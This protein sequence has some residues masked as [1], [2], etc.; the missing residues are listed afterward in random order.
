L[1]SQRLEKTMASEQTVSTEFTIKNELGFH[2][3]PI[4]RFAEL[5]RAFNSEIE[6][7]VEE[8]KAAGKSILHIR[9]GT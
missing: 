6:V 4:Q 8:R 7:Q 9:C 1:V 2:V 5:A 3:R